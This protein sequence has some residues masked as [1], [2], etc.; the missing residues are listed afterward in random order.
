MLFDLV[1]LLA[2][3]PAAGALLLLLGG[4]R[5]DPWGHLL[6]TGAGAASFAL[7]AVMLVAMLGRDAEDRVIRQVSYAW[8]HV[9]G[10]QVDA[11]FRLDP[12]SIAFVLLITG[13]G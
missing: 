12:L 13:V 4:R 8:V 7:A 11:A 1:W 6:A 10:F 9:G 2:A 3:L 5:T